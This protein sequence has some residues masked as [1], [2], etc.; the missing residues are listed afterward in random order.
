MGGRHPACAD[1]LVSEGLP[2]GVH[3]AGVGYHA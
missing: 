3:L 1:V 2:A